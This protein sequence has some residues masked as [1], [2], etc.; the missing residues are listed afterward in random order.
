MS[1][2]T[3]EAAASMRSSGWSAGQDFDTDR[4]PV[5][6]ATAQGALLQGK[7][8]CVIR[9]QAADEANPPDTRAG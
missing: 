2:A 8:Q 1:S 9:S 4:Q 7:A 5:A 6:S 3:A